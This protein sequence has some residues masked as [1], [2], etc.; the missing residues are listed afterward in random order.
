MADK[1]QRF[2][3]VMTT[4][5]RKALDALARQERI[6]QAAVLRRLIWQAAIKAGQPAQSPTR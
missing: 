1:E 5:E 2:G 4:E 6:S 3:L